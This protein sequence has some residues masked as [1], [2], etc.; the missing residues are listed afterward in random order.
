MSREGA[1]TKTR[2]FSILCTRLFFSFFFFYT[3]TN[4][5]PQH[6]DGINQGENGVEKEA[7]RCLSTSCDCFLL[8]LL[9]QKRIYFL[10]KRLLQITVRSLQLLK[11]FLGLNLTHFLSSIQAFLFFSPFLQLLYIYRFVR[12]PWSLGWIF[13]FFWVRGEGEGEVFLS[14]IPYGSIVSDQLYT[15]RL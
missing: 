9:R 11:G 13:F 8:P 1:N 10:C 15:A 6:R 4:L 3:I 7:F 5:N 14:R 2:V 12:Y